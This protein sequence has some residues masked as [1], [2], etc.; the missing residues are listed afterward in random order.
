MAPY[1]LSSRPKGWKTPLE[2]LGGVSLP[3]KSR[4]FLLDR[5]DH[6]TL[7]G[8]TFGGVEIIYVESQPVGLTY[9]RR[10]YRIRHFT[11]HFRQVCDYL[12]TDVIIV[13]EVE[14]DSMIKRFVMEELMKDL[15]NNI[16]GGV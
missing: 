1:K 5:N 3:L 13:D 6:A 9:K 11:R 8:V 7:F 2:G 4:A 10:N 15:D 16:L 14:M 12:T